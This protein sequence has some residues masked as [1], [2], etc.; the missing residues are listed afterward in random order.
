MWRRTA[1]AALVGVLTGCG[2]GGGGGGGSSTDLSG[3]SAIN[4]EDFIEIQSERLR[5]AQLGC[6]IDV[7]VWNRTQGRLFVG[8]VYRSF[9][10]SGNELAT[11]SASGF[12]NGS[13]TR[14]LNSGGTI[15]LSCSRIAR[16]ELHRNASSIVTN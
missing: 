3:P 8:L 1:V 14:V 5:T 11:L 15:G 9:D 2:G 12:L 4:L 6:A 10:S 7:R 16:F 13:D